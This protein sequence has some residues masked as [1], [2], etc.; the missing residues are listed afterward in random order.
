MTE[1]MGEMPK[2]TQLE[3]VGTPH[4]LVSSS[5]LEGVSMNLAKRNEMI[6]LYEYFE[7]ANK[8]PR[9]FEGGDKDLN[10][11]NETFIFKEG[12]EIKLHDLAE[13][14]EMLRLGGFNADL[15]GVQAIGNKNQVV[16]AMVQGVDEQKANSGYER[17][18]VSEGPHMIVAPYAYD[19]DGKLH[20]FRLIQHRTGSASIDTVRG[21]MDAQTLTTGS[22]VYKVEGSEANV[23]KNLQ[24]MIKE[25][26]GE[27]FLKVR[28]VEYLG[29]HVVNKSFVVSPSALFGVEVDYEAFTQLK[30]VL[31][32]EEAQ[33]RKDTMEHEGLT[34]IVIDMT[35]EQYVHYKTD[36]TISKDMAA[37]SATDIIMMGHLLQNQ[38]EGAPNKISRAATG[39]KNFF[40]G[41]RTAA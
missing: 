27:K 37:D 1:G 6:P 39:V 41:K 24:R 22:H 21:F 23:Q 5:V 7:R 16:A 15:L 2:I 32:P 35:P 40:G 14:Q 17:P 28:K 8:K 10:S 38:R 36:P 11:H 3:P 20:I 9:G 34:E 19:K 33:R 29:S 31:S 4:E 12:N 30:N 13:F 18:T 26:A 25:E